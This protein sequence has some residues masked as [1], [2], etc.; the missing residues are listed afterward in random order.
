MKI[1]I[2]GRCFITEAGFHPG[3]PS[4]LVRWA[5]TQMD[6]LT[7]AN[8][9]GVIR[10]NWGALDI[11]DSTVTEFLDELRS[12]DLSF[13]RNKKW[14]RGSVISMKGF[15]RNT[16]LNNKGSFWFSP[17]FFQE[18]KA[19]P[20]MIESL[21]ETGFFIAGFHWF[22]DY[23]IFPLVLFGLTLLPTK[24]HER[25]AQFFFHRLAAVSKPP[26]YTLLMLEAEGMLDGHTQKLKLQISH[27]NGYWFTAI[28]VAAAIEQWINPNNRKPGLHL[29]GHFVDT[30]IFFPRLEAL[31]I[32]QTNEAQ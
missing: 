9:Y 19:L 32:Q 11:N 1:K 23:F 18:M 24:N 15:T 28:P 7:K 26:F 3:I 27:E 22:I 21:E 20:N 2:A 16:L 14:K 30:N 6:T 10:E 17:M 12:M 5:A 4:A 8:I 25:L 29:M 13:Y 31:G